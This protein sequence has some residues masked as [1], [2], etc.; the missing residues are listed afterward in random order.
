MDPLANAEDD[1]AILD[2]LLKVGEQ[3]QFL[4]VSPVTL[5][6]VRTEEVVHLEVPEERYVLPEETEEVPLGEVLRSKKAR[7]AATASSGVTPIGKRVAENVPLEG[8]K[9]KRPRN[10]NVPGQEDGR[11]TFEALAPPAPE[12]PRVRLSSV[13]GEAGVADEGFVRRMVADLRD[14]STD[15]LLA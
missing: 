1:Y 12:V 3:A 5:E 6:V 10:V 8:A 14:T 15:R 9:G 11:V 13:L 4:S 2:E 7:A